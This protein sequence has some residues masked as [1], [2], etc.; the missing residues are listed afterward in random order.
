MRVLQPELCRTTAD[1]RGGEAQPAAMERQTRIG[2]V[3]LK[4]ADPDSTLPEGETVLGVVTSGSGPRFEVTGP[5]ELRISLMDLVWANGERD[6]RALAA[7][8]P[9]AI[10]RLDSGSLRLSVYKTPEGL[11]WIELSV[12]QIRPGAADRRSN[13]RKARLDQLDLASGVDAVQTLSSA[14]ATKI[15]SK[16]D[17]LGHTDKRRSYLCA[18]LPWDNALLPATAYVLTRVLPLLNEYE[19]EQPALL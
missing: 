11:G 4:L 18:V 5:S 10:R 7:E 17:V 15:G 14:G 8:G 2:S 3:F 1:L 16:E 9:K 6:V 12:A 13:L 19:G